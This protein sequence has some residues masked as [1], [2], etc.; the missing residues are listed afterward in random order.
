MPDS[1][2][3][4]TLP[5]SNRHVFSLGLGYKTGRHLSIDVVYQ[6]SLSESRTIRKSADANFDGTGDLNGKWQSDSHAIVITT[7]YKF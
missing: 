3:S 2:F 4:P 1:T 7:T 5:D 6:Y